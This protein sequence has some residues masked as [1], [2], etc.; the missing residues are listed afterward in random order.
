MIN[1]LPGH[2]YRIKDSC[3]LYKFSQQNTSLGSTAVCHHDR[4]S[5]SFCFLARHYLCP[6]YVCL[7]GER[8]FPGQAG[9]PGAPGFPGPEGPVGPRGEKVR[10]QL[11]IG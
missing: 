1:G 5:D 9:Q 2:W 7:Q 11:S 4:K 3:V 6:V 8:G 10:G